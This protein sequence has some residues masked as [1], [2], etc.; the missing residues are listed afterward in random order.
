MVSRNK[1]NHSGSW[2]VLIGLATPFLVLLLIAVAVPAGIWQ[3]LD[4]MRKGA[5]FILRWN[6]KG[7]V[8]NSLQR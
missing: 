4:S 5:G 8:V 3:Y 7:A 6:K 1:T 2:P